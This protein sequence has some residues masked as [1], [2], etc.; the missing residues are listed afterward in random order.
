MKKYVGLI[1]LLGLVAGGTWF[2]ALQMQSPAQIAAQ[3]EAPSPKPVLSELKRGYLSK[4]LSMRAEANYS[5]TQTVQPISA[6]EGVVTAVSKKRGDTLKNGDVLM[7]ISGEPV[8][9]LT[10]PFAPYRDI[11][12]NDVGDDVQVLQSALQ[13]AGYSTGYD[14]EGLFGPG[15]QSALRRMYQAAQFEVPTNRDIAGAEDEEGEVRAT[16][17]ALR[18][19][20]IFVPNLPATIEHVASVGVDIAEA[21]WLVKLGTGAIKLTATVPTAAIGSLELGAAGTFIGDDGEEQVAAV[22]SIVPVDDNGIEMLVT[23]TTEAKIKPG[24]EVVVTV[25]N[26]SGETEESLLAPQAAILTRGDSSYIYVPD[27]EKFRE[28]QVEVVG[29]LGG[30]VAIEVDDASIDAGSEVRVE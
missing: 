9:V 15:T 13:E 25:A 26:P 24:S 27:G 17:A 16:P 11:I 21:D 19:H 20:I 23:F 18:N 3:A 30:Q 14:R 8:F 12:A 4:P 5:K 1:L 29:S 10:G 6:A 28:V 2:L 7:R 22:E